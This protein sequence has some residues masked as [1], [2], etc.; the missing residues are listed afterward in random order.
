MRVTVFNEYLHE[1]EDERVARVYPGGIHEALEAAIE[2]HVPGA[3]VRSATLREP[4]H[5][6]PQAVVDDTDVMLWW[7]HKAHGDVSDAV[8]ERVQRAVLDG[9]GLVVLHS[10][11]LSKPFL[12]LMGTHGSLKWREADE[13]E[14]LWNLQPAHP[15]L[16]GVPDHVELE[17]EEM[18]GER[19][20]VPEPDELLMISW[21][22]GGEVFRSLM[23]WRRGLGRVVYFR[24][25]HETYPTYHDPV[26]RRIVANCSTYAAARMRRD[27]SACPNPA[28]LESVPNPGKEHVLKR[29]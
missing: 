29:S 9:M 1:L 6:L 13:K 26:V 17:Q 19:F 10:G 20:D 11:H 15:I 5:G 22:Q 27:D 16:E 28:A 24:P 12:R 4:E 25:G 14:R 23:T 18:Y 3:I 21:F 8:A 7:G 2:D